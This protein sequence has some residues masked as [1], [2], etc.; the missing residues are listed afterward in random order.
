MMKMI[1]SLVL[2]ASTF[3]LTAQTGSSVSSPDK[4]IQLTAGITDGQAWY[5]VQYKG[6]EVLQKSK[7]GIERQ[8][9]QFTDGLVLKGASP[10]EK[11]N[12]NYTSV[13]AKKSSI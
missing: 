3:N 13:N 4:N 10:L 12:D 11:V 6:N 5:R 2:L 8:D 9:E 1:L 7:L